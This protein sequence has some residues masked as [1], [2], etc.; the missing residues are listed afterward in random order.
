MK[1]LKIKGENITSLSQFEID[2]RDPVFEHNGL[3]AITGPTGSGKS[4]LLDCICL[5]LYGKT[6]RYTSKKSTFY[7]GLPEQSA[8]N[9]LSANDPRSL[10]SHGASKIFAEV[11]FIGVHQK[12]YRSSWKVRRAHGK[13]TG[14]LQNPEVDLFEWSE[15]KKEYVSKTSSKRT[16]TLQK[17]TDAVGLKFTQFCRS[18]FLAQGE[19][20]AF[21]K[22][23]GRER[24]ELLQCMT[25]TE[26]YEDLSKAANDRYKKAKKD[27]QEQEDLQG[28]DDLLSE[29]QAAD[30]TQKMTVLHDNVDQLEEQRADQER[31]VLKFEHM[32]SL[33][34]TL[35]QAQNEYEV[36]LDQITQQHLQFEQAKELKELIP[37]VALASQVDEAKEIHDQ[38]HDTL[39]KLLHEDGIQE[40]KLKH[41]QESEEKSYVQL[42]DLE[43]KW[44]RMTQVRQQ[45]QHLDLSIT[46][47]QDQLNHLSGNIQQ[48]EES[49][50]HCIDQQTHNKER[51]NDARDIL[52]V[53]ERWIKEHEHADR[54]SQDEAHWSHLINQFI[55]LYQERT[56]VRH[57]LSQTEQSF[58]KSSKQ[59]EQKETQLQAAESKLKK[60]QHDYKEIPEGTENLVE[61]QKQEALHQQE[62][63]EVEQSGRLIQQIDQDLQ[64]LATY[65]KQEEDLL[66]DQNAINQ[67]LKDKE[68]QGIKLEAKVEALEET[69]TLTQHQNEL[70]SYREQLQEG[71]PCPLCGSCEHPGVVEQNTE[72]QQKLKDRIYELKQTLGLL[73][74]ERTK[75]HFEEARSQ[76]H[77][78]DLKERL[79]QTQDKVND[80]QLKYQAQASWILKLFPESESHQLKIDQAQDVLMEILEEKN[81]KRKALMEIMRQHV[82]WST[83]KEHLQSEEN[84]A[85]RKIYEVESELQLMNEQAKQTQKQIKQWQNKL[86]QLEQSFNQIAKE[87]NQYG[88]MEVAE[89]S[90]RA[91]QMTMVKWKALAK[92]WRKEMDQINLLNQSLQ[93][94]LQDQK[95]LELDLN[96]YKQERSQLKEQSIKQHKQLQFKEVERRSLDPQYEQIMQLDKELQVVKVETG[97]LKQKRHNLLV[98]KEER[99]SHLVQ[100]QVKSSETRTKHESFSR[101][102]HQGLLQAKFTHERLEQGKIQL[103]T[104]SIED[105]DALIESRTELDH[106]SQSL[107]LKIDTLIDTIQNQKLELKEVQSSSILKNELSQIKTQLQSLQS[108][109]FNYQSRWRKHKEALAEQGVLS[110]AYQRAKKE[111]ARWKVVHDLIGSVDGSKFRNF[112]QMLTLEMILDHANFYLKSLMPRY[113]LLPVRD[114]ELEFQVVDQD[115]GDELR[116]LRS[117]SGGESFLISLALALG[118]SKTSAQDTP[119]DSLFIDEGFGTLDTQS[120]DTA[121]SV[122]D[123]LQASGLQVGLIS[124][125]EGLAERIG[126]EIAVQPL[127]GGQS[128]LHIRNTF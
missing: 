122:L 110:A 90:Y 1:I 86:T 12:Q 14:T 6:P 26:I 116:S 59:K 43:Q 39:Q 103:D 51:I 18:V 84:Q 98:E 30:V 9:R 89:D 53:H 44:L 63:K 50:T 60:I 21:I 92:R 69:W 121:L 113:L 99:R 79:R 93:T 83:Q 117:L 27:L 68:V 102:L 4:T 87:L 20:D 37:L 107:K 76:G 32:L 72:L 112:V 82:T 42:N 80:H 48:K 118:L 29:E 35:T 104:A 23:P 22:A 38:T 73:Q 28:T 54:L 70:A 124:H 96:R 123:N 11:D 33:E 8:K 57:D 71:E 126:I 5:A 16:E 94:E 64:L 77:I 19:F 36:C 58:A 25:G 105:L 46:Q 114:S 109:L 120:L 24:G 127:G 17:I 111:V 13:S 47:D 3:F 95:I 108:E 2:L 7:I 61:L 81:Q 91:A 45:I 62:I 88:Y 115:F 75:L 15:E 67:E 74:E 40:K 49:L 128:E 66:K 78:A 10:M 41:L 125:V 52:Q 106:E 85:H 31:K 100:H 101:Q 97:H 34:K 119:I 56:Q 55:S 65:Q